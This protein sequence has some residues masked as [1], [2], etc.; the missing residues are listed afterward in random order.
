[1]HRFYEPYTEKPCSISSIPYNVIF[2]FSTTSAAWFKG[3]PAHSLFQILYYLPYT[4]IITMK[5]SPPIE[6][7]VYSMDI[8]FSANSVPGTLL[9]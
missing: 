2:L 7:F 6:M 1:M 5:S 8:L 9:D 4:V 3:P